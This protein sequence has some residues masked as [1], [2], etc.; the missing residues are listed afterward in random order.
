MLSTIALHV[1]C[2]KQKCH[3]GS[4]EEGMEA[5]MSFVFVVS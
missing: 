2:C 5:I 4:G 3:M 1:S